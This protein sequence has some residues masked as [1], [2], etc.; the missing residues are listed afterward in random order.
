[1][2]KSIQKKIKNLI[3]IIDNDL[4]IGTLKL[5]KFFD[6]DHSSLKRL[7]KN[8]FEEFCS[9]DGNEPKS[10][11]VKMDFKS[12]LRN[13]KSLEY[14]LNEPQSMYLILL[15]KNKDIVRKFKSHLTREFF[16][17]R[18]YI[19][20]LLAQKQNTEWLE[21]REQGKIERRVETDAIKEFVDYAIAQGSVNAKK[22]YMAIS[23][24][25]NHTLF[26]LDMLEMKFPNL[27]DLL[28][29]YQLSTLQNADRI[30]ARALK[31]GI[32]KTMFYK[33][34]YKLAKVKLETFVTLIGKTPLN[35]ISIENYEKP[36]IAK[37]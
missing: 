11:L 28:G 27:R 6:L 34:I 36:Q 26:N 7:V 17:Q 16:R 3:E 31:A 35:N 21:K 12:T 19:I 33:D 29:G 37:K 15:S 2:D 8:H 9:F 25:E 13:R 10:R 20:K 18:K 5:S 1:M 14:L 4:Y 23:K 30:V 24:M 22:Y 32:N